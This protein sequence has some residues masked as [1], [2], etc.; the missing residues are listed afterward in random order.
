VDA[1]TGETARCQGIVR[2]RGDYEQC[3]RPQGHRGRRHKRGEWGGQRK[4][5]LSGRRL[6]RIWSGITQGRGTRC[7]ECRAEVNGLTQGEPVTACYVRRRLPA[8][9]RTEREWRVEPCGHVFTEVMRRSR[10]GG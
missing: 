1:V 4:R 3:A 7:P 6:R 2:V 10:R 5:R 9:V 8:R